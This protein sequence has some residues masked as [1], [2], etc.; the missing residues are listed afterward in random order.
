MTVIILKIP[1]RRQQKNHPDTDGFDLCL[2]VKGMPRI[3]RFY[4]NPIRPV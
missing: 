4:F 1:N 2:S 3:T